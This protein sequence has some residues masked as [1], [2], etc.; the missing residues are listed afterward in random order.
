MNSTFQQRLA[1]TS[2]AL[3]RRL[4]AEFCAA[5]PVVL[6]FFTGF[7]LVFLLF[8][9]FVAQYSIEFSAFSK[10]I[11]GAAILGKV[12]LIMEWVYSGRHLDE[13]PRA[14]AV[15][16]KTFIYG[17]AG[18]AVVIAD[19]VIEGYREAG[20]LREGVALMIARAQLERALGTVLLVS[21]LTCAYLVL[22]E[23][24]RAMGEGALFRLFFRRPVDT[25]KA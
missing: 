16:Y 5:V 10:A 17:V 2:K 22:L 9:L 18:L 4:V 19:R 3:A 24:N 8:K 7:L 13:Y 20:S 12:I 11:I 14:V 1:R 15:L 25:R 23:I 6:F 21:S